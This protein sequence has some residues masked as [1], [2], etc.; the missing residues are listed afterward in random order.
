[1]LDGDRSEARQLD[2]ERRLGDRRLGD[3]RTQ[4]LTA[5]ACPR[6]GSQYIGRSSTRW[7]ERPVRWMTPLLPFRCRT[8]DWRGWRRADWVQL[9]RE[10]LSDRQAGGAAPPEVYDQETASQHF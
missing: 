1:M 6:C 10:G 2:R 5:T 4:Q 7:W 3:R 9:R 8:C